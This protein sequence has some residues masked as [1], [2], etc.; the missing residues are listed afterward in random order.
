[1]SSKRNPYAARQ[2]GTAIDSVDFDNTTV[3][4]VIEELEEWQESKAVP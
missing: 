3:A 1:M 2:P 4:T